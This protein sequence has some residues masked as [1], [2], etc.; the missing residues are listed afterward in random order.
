MKID[1]SKCFFLFFILHLFL[2]NITFQT[3]N[4]AILSKV[5]YKLRIYLNSQSLCMYIVKLNTNYSISAVFDEAILGPFYL[6]FIIL[7]FI[8]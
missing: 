1:H 5:I 6:D 8:F 7:Y 3:L 2:S 4:G